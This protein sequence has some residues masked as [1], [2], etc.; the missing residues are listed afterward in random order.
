MSLLKTLRRVVCSLLVWVFL[1]SIEWK[2]QPLF[3][4]VSETLVHNSLVR[5][6]DISLKKVYVL[7]KER[8]RREL[9]EPREDPI[10][11]Y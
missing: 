6:I 3:Y 7:A 2:G 1:L 9:G 4:Y 11:I 10:E 5:E 8:I